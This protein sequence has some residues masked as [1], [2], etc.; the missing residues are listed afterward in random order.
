MLIQHKK[1]FLLF[2]IL[3]TSLL[4]C[5]INL[6]CAET[7]IQISHFTDKSTKPF[8]YFDNTNNKV[9]DKYYAKRRSG[10]EKKLQQIYSSASDETKPWS[11]AFNFKKVW[12]TTVDPRTG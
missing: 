6:F 2:F 3:I 10:S 5:T 1:I 4:C 8:D 9:T 11:N 7:N 12:G